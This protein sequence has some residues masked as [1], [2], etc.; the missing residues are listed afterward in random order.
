MG[1]SPYH[2][3]SASRRSRGEASG[4]DRVTNWATP[5]NGASVFSV[6]STYNPG[7][8]PYAPANIID[9]NDATPWISNVN[10]VTGTN[11]IIDLG[12]ARS[13][14]AARVLNLTYFN[15]FDL[16]SSSSSG[17]PWTRRASGASKA[18]IK[19][20]FAAPVSARYWRLIYTSGGNGN[21]LYGLE[22][23][24]VVH[25][26][27]AP[28]DWGLLVNGGSPA[29]SS[30]FAGSAY[31]PFDGNDATVWV[32][33]DNNLSGNT[34]AR[35]FLGGVVPP[36]YSIRVKNVTYTNGWKVQSSPD[37]STWTDRMTGSGPN[38]TTTI[39][40]APVTEPYWRVVYISGS[41]GNGLATFSLF[42]APQV[43]GAP[44]VVIA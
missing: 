27:T 11:A 16:E 28:V 18:D 10:G 17:G 23:L 3:R 34:W 2:G 42:G 40:G 29:V 12:Q 6:S 13:V 31:D 43:L 8:N 39:L 37:A 35:V 26:R 44:V 4:G 30:S 38:D 24:D 9:G 5:G 25:S 7:G 41:S 21:E 36:I 1:A 33:N 22:L 19:L 20:D 15:T 32:S 14:A